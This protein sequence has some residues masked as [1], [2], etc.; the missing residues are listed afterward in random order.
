LK[1]YSPKTQPVPAVPR[2]FKL[3]KEKLQ[4]QA[5]QSAADLIQWLK[6]EKRNF[7]LYSPKTLPVPAM[8]WSFK[9]IDKELQTQVHPSA[10]GP[11]PVLEKYKKKLK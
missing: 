1:E 10:A 3:T 5:H 11:N 8:P 2:G 9:F 7:N 6:N 4:T